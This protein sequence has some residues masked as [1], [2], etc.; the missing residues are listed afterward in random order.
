MAMYDGKR[1]LVRWTLHRHCFS[2]RRVGGLG[3][4]V[5]RRGEVGAEGGGGLGECLGKTL[6]AGRT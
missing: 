1:S 6:G 3:E 4:G 5:E 2:E